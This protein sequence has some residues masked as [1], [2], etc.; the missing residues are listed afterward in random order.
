MRVRMTKELQ[1]VFRGKGD[2]K[3]TDILLDR[4]TIIFS[5]EINQ[6]ILNT[7][8]IEDPIIS[9]DDEYRYLDFEYD[10]R[11]KIKSTLELDALTV[12]FTFGC[13]ADFD[14]KYRLTKNGKHGTI[15]IRQRTYDELQLVMLE[16]KDMCDYIDFKTGKIYE[17]CK[18][19]HKRVRIFT[20]VIGARQFL[21]KQPIYDYTLIYRSGNKRTYSVMGTAPIDTFINEAETYDLATDGRHLFVD[22]TFNALLIPTPLF[23]PYSYRMESVAV[24]PL[25]GLNGPSIPPIPGMNIPSINEP[26]QTEA[27]VVDGEDENV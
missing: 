26:V 10:T 21:G 1:K 6:A 7:I 27:K 23:T 15:V 19:G 12:Y 17:E 24:P 16:N 2:T 14:G 8:E 11:T 3:S 5:E 4:F 22:N 9:T 20:G 18:G 13:I 25:D